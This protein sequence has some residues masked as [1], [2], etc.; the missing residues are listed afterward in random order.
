MFLSTRVSGA[1]LPTLIAGF[2][3]DRITV[4]TVRLAGR[5]CHNF[6]VDPPPGHGRLV[7]CSLPPFRSGLGAH[8]QKNLPG[9]QSFKTSDNIDV[10]LE[11]ISDLLRHLVLMP[12]L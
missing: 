7:L 6:P 9:L 4:L 2:G 12:V 3:V 10:G 1:P 5:R 11:G 8:H